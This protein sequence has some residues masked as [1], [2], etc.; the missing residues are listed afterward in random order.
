MITIYVTKYA[1]TSGIKSETAKIDPDGWAL[2]DRD[3]F[4]K[5]EYALTMKDAIVQAKG[6]RDRKVASLKRQIEKFEKMYG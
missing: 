1:L 6:K 2:V 3:Y 5:S 4:S